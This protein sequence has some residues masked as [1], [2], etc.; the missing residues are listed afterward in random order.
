MNRRGYTL[1]RLQTQSDAAQKKISR[2]RSVSQTNPTIVVFRVE[3][4]AH[5]AAVQIVI[6]PFK[7]PDYPEQV[8]YRASYRYS[9]C[10]DALQRFD[11]PVIERHV[12]DVYDIYFKPSPWNFSSKQR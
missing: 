4:A 2:D 3:E 7:H 5:F 10:S 12:Q 6:A 11:H 8:F 9:H 1:I